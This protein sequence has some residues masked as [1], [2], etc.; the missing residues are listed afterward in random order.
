MHTRHFV[1][2]PQYTFNEC[3]GGDYNAQG[4]EV[5]LHI[6]TNCGDFNLIAN[7]PQNL[8][9]FYTQQISAFSANFPGI[10]APIT[11]RHHCIAWSDWVTG[12]E[13]QLTHGIRLDTNYYFWP[14]GWVQNRPG[15][16]NGSAMP[17]RFSDSRR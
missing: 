5:G 2:I 16:F 8:E 17:M 12:A 1:H 10:P 3:P 15:F 6:N 7:N 14:P 11:Q 4:F 13:V 9:T